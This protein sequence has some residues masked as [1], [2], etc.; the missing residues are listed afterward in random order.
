MIRKR[1]DIQL[2][3]EDLH[4]ALPATQAL[5]KKEID[6]KPAWNISRTL[7]NVEKAIK[8]VQDYR[9]KRQEEHQAFKMVGEG[10]QAVKKYEFELDEDKKPTNKPVWLSDAHK[11]A[12]EKIVE[13]LAEATS[14]FLAFQIHLSDLPEKIKASALFK[15][16]WLFDDIDAGDELEG[17]RKQR[18]VEIENE[19]LHICLSALYQL[20][21]KDLDRKAASNLARTLENVEAIIKSVQKQRLEIQ[22]KY[23]ESTGRGSSIEYTV[24][25]DEQT[26]KS[27]VVWKSEADEKAFEQEVEELSKAKSTV[28]VHQLHF[29]D[30]PSKV[31]ATDLFKLYWLFDDLEEDDPQTASEVQ[32]ETIVEAAA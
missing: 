22:H 17:A 27:T 6:T 31:K 26:K 5:A 28:K 13:D 8:K 19:E 14:D 11:K 12:Y 32:S 2:E 16:S 29:G 10:D 1:I 25:V 7:E 4:H 9:Q 15:I 3:N 18:E 30:L 24:K 21:D 23:Q 20:T